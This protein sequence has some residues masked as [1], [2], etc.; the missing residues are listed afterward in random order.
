MKSKNIQAIEN[1]EIPCSE[2]PDKILEGIIHQLRHPIYSI[3]GCLKV[4]QMSFEEELKQDMII[5]NHEVVK[6]MEELQVLAHNYLTTCFGSE[7]SELEEDVS[8][9]AKE[10]LEQ[11]INK[12]QEPINA[13]KE[14]SVTLKESTDEIER[15][16]AMLKIYRFIGDIEELQVSTGSRLS[17][18]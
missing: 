14:A 9:S 15:L 16:K 7:G 13:I 18:S 6:E 1:P 17:S 11:F 3:K 8:L 5:F 4:L 12:L 2:P 10:V